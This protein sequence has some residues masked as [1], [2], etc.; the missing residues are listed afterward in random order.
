MTPRGKRWIG[1]GGRFK[2]SGIA[3]ILVLLS[4]LVLSVLAASIVFTARSETFASYG[5]RLDTQAKAGIEAAVN[6]LRSNHYAAVPNG[7]ANADYIVTAEPTFTLYTSNSSPVQCK[8]NC[9][10]I[11]GPVQL[12]GYGGGSTN[13]PSGIT[14]A[15]SGAAISVSFTNNLNSHG[16]GS[17][18]GGLVSGSGNQSGLFFVNAYLL[19]YQTVNSSSI[20][21][22]SNTNSGLNVPPCPLETWLITAKGE[23]I[24]GSSQVAATAEEQA[25]VQPVY[26]SSFGDAMYGYCSVSMAGSAGVCTDAFN[27]AL[28]AY[29]GGNTSVAAGA[30]DSTTATNVINADA[31]VGANGYVSLSSNVT[32]SGN[33]IIGNANPSLIPSSCCSGSSCGAPTSGTVN[34]SIITGAAYTAPPTAPTF[35]GSGQSGATFPGTSPS[36]SGAAQVPQ[37]SSSSSTSPCADPPTCT[38]TSPITPGTSNPYGWPCVTGKT[39][40]GSGANPYLISSVSLSGNG[41]TLTLYGGPSIGQPVYYDVDSIGMS[42]KGQL[43]VNGYVVLNVKTSLSLTGQGILNGLTQA[44]EAVQINYAGTGG[45]SIGGNGAMSAVLTAP[46]ATV[47]LGGGGSKGYMFGSIRALNVSVQGGY[48]LHYDVALNRLDGILGQ[49]AVSSYTRI[50]H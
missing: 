35:P 7:S 48:P 43:A 8:A 23:W 31:N 28:G 30:C 46:N 40:N 38:N 39:C 44:A 50:K 37:T 24:I 19:N 16:A 49:V 4:M 9:A 26:S 33:V 36:Y 11:N 41:D 47:S 17:G 32:V 21:S 45:V 22:C 25:I 5:Y 10:S 3:L 34:G 2:D 12:I 20:A 1:T 15:S 6:W 18:N 29:G 27:S 14:N 42:G 13:Y